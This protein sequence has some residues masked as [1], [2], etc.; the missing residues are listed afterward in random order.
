[1]RMMWAATLIALV[2]GCVSTAN[3]AALCEATASARR[4][5]AAALVADG[6]DAS[7]LTGQRL[8]AKIKAGCAE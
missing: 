7:V 5:H 4:A 6:G 8:L 2:S 3:E 1:M